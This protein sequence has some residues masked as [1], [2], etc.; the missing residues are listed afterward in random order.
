MSEGTQLK[1]QV[2]WHG[3]RAAGINPGSE[4]IT[5]HFRYGQPIDRDTIDYFQGIIQE[6]YDGA[7]VDFVE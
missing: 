2:Q 7:Q 4:E 1:F 6:F 3:E 5:I